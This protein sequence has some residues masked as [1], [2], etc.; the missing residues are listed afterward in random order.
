MPKLGVRNEAMATSMRNIIEHQTC[1]PEQ[2]C[3][4]TILLLDCQV[5]VTAR[6]EGC[7]FLML[8][9]IRSAAGI[10]PLEV[11]DDGLRLAMSRDL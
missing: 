7:V 4:L 3:Q 1:G 2:E 8:Q 9:E 11:A 10:Q 5:R 6:M